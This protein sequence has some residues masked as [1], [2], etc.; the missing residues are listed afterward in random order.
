[1]RRYNLDGIHGSRVSEW[2]GVVST[3]V[4]LAGLA[5]V[6][7]L[8]AGM[9]M[10]GRARHMYPRMARREPTPHTAQPRFGGTG[11]LD[12]SPAAITP[13]EERSNR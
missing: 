11:A 4:V 7:G 12:V 9:M 3:P 13:P 8:A 1:M 2:R 6:L 10:K 5:F